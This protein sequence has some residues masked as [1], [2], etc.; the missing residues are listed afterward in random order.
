VVAEVL[1]VDLLDLRLCVGDTDLTPVDLGSYS[2]RVTMMVGHAAREAAERARDLIAVAVAEKLEIPA[3]RLEFAQRRVFDRADPEKGLDF[4]EAVVVAESRFGTLGTTGSYIP[5][6]SPGRYRGAGVGPSPAYSYSAAVI[7]VD[8]DLTTGLYTVE[9]VWIAHD[10]GR[11]INPALVLGQVEGSVYMGL[12]EAMMEEQAF[13]R[14][15]K[16]R[17]NALVHKFPS[18]LEYKSPTFLDMPKVTTYLIENPDPNGPYG[19]KEVG[20]G[21]LLPIVPALAN[22]IHDAAGVRIDQVPIGP[23]MIRKALEEKAKGRTARFG[24]PP[25]PKVDFGEALRVKTKEEGGDGTAMNAERFGIRHG[26][27]TMAER[28]RPLGETKP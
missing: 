10:I 15:P 21:P 12:G 3:S 24:P 5:P 13:R 16:S 18:L 27:G 1:G 6:R 7:E 11:S 9:H 20:Q 14:L 4:S 19:A 8:V 22:A 17:S 28:E 23:Q 2:S 25:F 26:T